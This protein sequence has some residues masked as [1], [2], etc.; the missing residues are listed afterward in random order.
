MVDGVHAGRDF[1]F[2]I[3]AE[4]VGVLVSHGRGK[5][6]VR[7][8]PGGVAHALNVAT[9]Q[10]ICGVDLDT[11]EVFDSDFIAD[12]WSFHCPTC[13]METRRQRR[14]SSQRVPQSGLGSDN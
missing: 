14:S 2:A 4:W 7:F 9:G 13:E 6:G 1:T 12:S 3:A 5:G 10:V 8:A 11:L